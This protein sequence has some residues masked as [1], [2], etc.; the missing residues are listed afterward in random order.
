MKY[1]TA[2]FALAA[3]LPTASLADQVSLNFGGDTYTAGQTTTI[4]VPVSRDAFAAGYLTTP[5]RSETFA[6]QNL[7]TYN[8]HHP[9]GVVYNWTLNIQ[10]MIRPIAPSVS[11]SQ[12][13]ETANIDAAC[14]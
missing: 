4:S 10:Q 1:L 3:L 5:S 7:R 12:K 8:R 2:F 6:G 11:A 14:E 13:P 9:M